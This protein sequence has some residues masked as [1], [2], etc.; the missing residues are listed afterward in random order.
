MKVEWTLTTTDRTLRSTEELARAVEVPG[1]L[2]DGS[3]LIGIVILAGRMMG[4]RLKTISDNDPN[5]K[6]GFKKY[7]KTLDKLIEIKKGS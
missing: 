7:S 4:R 3:F 6:F 1:D 5:I 2:L